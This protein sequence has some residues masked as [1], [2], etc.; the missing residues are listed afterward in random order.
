MLVFLSHLYQPLRNRT[1]CPRQYAVSDLRYCAISNVLFLFWRKTDFSASFPWIPH[2]SAAVDI[3]SGYPWRCPPLLPSRGLRP[4]SDGP[5]Q[6]RN[7]PTNTPHPRIQF[8]G[9]LLVLLQ[10][11]RVHQYGRSTRVLGCTM[12]APRLHL[13]PGCHDKPRGLGQMWFQEVQASSRSCFLR[14]CA[15]RSR[16]V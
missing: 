1:P 8:A 9:I 2:L 11:S 7:N 16:S 15:L 6:P 12:P 10:Y 3:L 5:P 13:I 4:V 14:V